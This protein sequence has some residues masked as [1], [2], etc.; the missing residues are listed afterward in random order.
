MSDAKLL[1]GRCV[2]SIDLPSLIASSSGRATAEKYK[3]KFYRSHNNSLCGYLGRTVLLGL[4][5]SVIWKDCEGCRNRL[6]RIASFQPTVCMWLFVVTHLPVRKELYRM[7]TKRKRKYLRER[8]SHWESDCSQMPV[9]A[10]FQ[11]PQTSA[12][13]LWG[14]MQ[15]ETREC[16]LWG[17]MYNG[18]V[19]SWDLKARG[20]LTVQDMASMISWAFWLPFAAQGCPRP[21]CLEDSRERGRLQMD[22]EP[23]VKVRLTD[24]WRQK[25]YWQK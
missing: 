11:S 23:S 6:W 22:M 17:L 3:P 21:P 12:W 1:H 24:T 20:P 25:P 5:F 19:R 10:P 16:F 14:G 8:G 9:S 18:N 7:K 4:L 2:P 15:V 13:A